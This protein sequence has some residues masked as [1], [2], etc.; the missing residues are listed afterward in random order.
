MKKTSGNERGILFNAI[1]AEIPWALSGISLLL[2][3]CLIAYSAKDPD[4][5]TTPLSIAA[6]YISSVVGG[7]FASRFS[8]GSFICAAT[9]GAISAF[10]IFLLSLIPIYDTGTDTVLGLALNALIIPSFLLGAFVGRPRA[11]AKKRKRAK[12]KKSAK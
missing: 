7:I 12:F 3:F 1:R 6:L 4:T 11:K 2:I 9:S 10:C 8:N 5:L